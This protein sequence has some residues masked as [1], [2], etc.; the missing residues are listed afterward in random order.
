MKKNKV[1]IFDL[2]KI[3]EFIFNGTSGRA[4]DVEIT[5]SFTYDKDTN[6]MLPSAKEIKEVK[7]DED[8]GKSTIRY[9]LM[10][11]FIDIVDTIDDTTEVSLGQGITLNTMQTY[12]LIK[13]ISQ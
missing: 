5:E 13:E 6:K 3:N 11:M 12:G 7:T 9:D 2:D 1:L 10:K 8:L 4:S